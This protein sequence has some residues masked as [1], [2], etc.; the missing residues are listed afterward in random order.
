MFKKSVKV[1]LDRSGAKVVA[2]TVEE[3]DLIQGIGDAFTAV[4]DDD[5]AVGGIGVSLAMV[6]AVAATAYGTNRI[7]SGRWNANPFSA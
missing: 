1:T 7:L 5:I 2:T 3:R 4:V 6:G